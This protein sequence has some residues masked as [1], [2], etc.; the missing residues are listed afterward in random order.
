ML[1][2]RR[3]H[4]LAVAAIVIPVVISTCKS[5]TEPASVPTT[6]NVSPGSVT[7]ATLGRT[8]QFSAVVLDQRGD[9]LHTAT[10]V[11]SSSDTTLVRVTAGGLGTAVAP[12]TAQVVATSASASGHATVTVALAAATVT[13]VS[14]D[15]Q[16]GTVGQA[17][18]AAVTVQVNDSSG[19]PIQGAT[20]SFTPMAASGSVSATAPSTDASGQAQTTWTLGT[21]AGVGRDTLTAQVGAVA[22]KFTASANPGPASQ[23]AKTAGDFQ[24]TEAGHAVAVPPQVAV[25]DQYGNAVAGDSVTFAVASGGGT[26]TG[27]VQLSSASGT[28]TVGSWTVGA[29]AGVNTLTATAKGV[30]APATFTDTAYVPGAPASVVAYAG[31]NN[32]P[33]LV[34]YNVNDRPAVVVKDAGN[35]LLAGVPVTFA[36][37]SGGGSGTRLVDTTNASGVAQVGSWVLGASPGVNT[38]TATVGALTPATFADTG[39]A[40]EYAIQLRYYGNYKPTAAESAAFNYAVTRWEAM[41]YRHVGPAVTVSDTAGTCGA[42][43][44]AINE[45]VTDL[46]IFASFDS[47]D[48]RGKTLAEAGPCF[49]RTAGAGTGLTLTGIMKF[50]TA[51]VGSLI[52]GGQ[53]GAVVLHEMGHVLGFGTLWSLAPPFPTVNCLQLPSNPPGTLQ[54]TYFSCAGGSQNAVA[55][56][57]SVGGSSYTGAGEPYGGNKVPV[58]N[59]ANAPYTYPTCGQGTVNSHWRTTVFGS[60][61]MVGFLP[62]SPKLSV[63]TVASLQDLGYTVNYAGADAYTNVFT[64]PPAAGAVRI[65]LGDDIHHGPLFGVDPSGRITLIRARQ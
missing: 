47:I 28:A 24:K 61:L 60:E 21:V 16:T 26:V 55:E 63:V 23:V 4:C 50:D 38:M 7:L 43:E 64:A 42:G 25:K 8:Q 49:I 5:S 54:D 32:Q 46:V 40:A 27:A 6:I 39:V 44:P 12:G 35:N 29:A 48:G 57:D 65:P 52:S 18:A 10:V 30:A 33:G 37:A 58:E 41:V 13:K 31:T 51:D 15:A 2:V 9:T 34:G 36:V 56:F 20:V 22:A 45:A 53:L 11:W 14:G 17:L 3:R 1:D 19:H 59:C 62:S